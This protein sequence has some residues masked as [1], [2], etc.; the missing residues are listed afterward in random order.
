MTST[1]TPDQDRA[2]DV[3]RDLLRAPEG[4]VMVL[5]G[6]AG[7]GKSWLLAQIAGE[8]PGLTVVTPTGKAALRIREVAG[9]PASTIHRFRYKAVTDPRTGEV[10]FVP[11]SRDELKTLAGRLLVVDE[12][13]MVGPQLW[14][15][16]LPAAEA[17]MRLLLVGDP[18]QLPPVDPDRTGWCALHHETPFRAH[19]AEVVRQAAESPV[20]RAAMAVRAATTRGAVQDAMRQLPREE[21]VEAWTQAWDRIRDAGD[22]DPLDPVPAICHTNRRRHAI[23]AA[24]RAGLPPGEVLHPGEPLLVLKNTYAIDRYNGEVLPFGHWIGAPTTEAVR[25]GRSGLARVLAYRLARVGAD[26]VVLCLQDID[27]TVPAEI[28][29]HWVRLGARAAVRRL[30]TWDRTQGELPPPYLQASWGYALTAHKAQGSQWDAVFVA[31]E[32]T[33]RIAEEEGRRWAYTAL[34]RAA[35]EATWSPA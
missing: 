24:M 13:S 17:G 10:E 1:L 35:R 18:F 26:D 22:E 25:D 30:A 31:L 12:A 4:S 16:I 14:R 29:E 6:L 3:F 7:T 15:E 2:M 8:A 23:N 33:V 28:G 21:S 19:L 20:L 34:T 32:E 27:G 11:R 5:T 9:L